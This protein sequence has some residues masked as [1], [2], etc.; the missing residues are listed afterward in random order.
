MKKYWIILLN[1]MRFRKSST[2]SF[3]RLRITASQK[4]DGI[5]FTVD[6]ILEAQSLADYRL[7]FGDA[8]LINTEI[9][10]Y[11]KVTREDIKRVANTYLKKENRVVLYY[12]PKSAE[13]Q[14]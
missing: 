3:P 10:R 12:L 9:K 1:C 4:T 7:F 11:Q 13:T 2:P 14:Q 8:N 5:I 6:L